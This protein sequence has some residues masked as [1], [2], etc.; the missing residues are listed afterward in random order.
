MNVEKID[1]DS[2]I[3]F[4]E[5]SKEQLK[6]SPDID[7]NKPVYLKKEEEYGQYFLLPTY[8][9]PMVM[10][11]KEIKEGIPDP[12]RPGNEESTIDESDSL[13]HLR[14]TQEIQG[15]NIQAEDG[16]I[17][18]LEDF[19]IDDKKSWRIEY[20]VIDTRNWLPGRKVLISANVIDKEIWKEKMVYVGLTKDEVKNSPRYDPG[21]PIN[22]RFEKQLYDYYGRPKKRIT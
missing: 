12:P 9:H 19:I 18:H 20:I 22:E 4:V 1:W 8:L 14:S 15:Y 3:I 10:P 17:G 6:K 13:P 7:T 5:M 2:K 21:E 16:K 11:L